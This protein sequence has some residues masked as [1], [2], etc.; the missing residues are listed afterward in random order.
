MLIVTDPVVSLA[1]LALG[2]ETFVTFRRPMLVGRY[3]ENHQTAV[4][5]N[6]RRCLTNT[7]GSPRN[8]KDLLKDFYSAFAD[9]VGK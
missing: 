7:R 5:L 4:E 9:R 3:K 8:V 1:C 6:P 2:E